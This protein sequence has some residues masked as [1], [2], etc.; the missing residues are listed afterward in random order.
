MAIVLLAVIVWF[1]LQAREDRMK[2][3]IERHFE[4]EPPV[5]RKGQ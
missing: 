3:D 2:K 4:N 1:L 5:R